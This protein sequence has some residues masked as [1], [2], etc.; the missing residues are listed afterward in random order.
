MFI[1][2]A[3]AEPAKVGT[4]PR[5]HGPAAQRNGSSMGDFARQT[6]TMFGGRITS[7]NGRAVNNVRPRGRQS[8][9]GR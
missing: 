6:G 3:Y 7:M 9:T 4:N 2:K 1:I 5:A 8:T